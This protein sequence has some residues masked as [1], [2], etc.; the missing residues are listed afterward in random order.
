MKQ[1]FSLPKIVF[2]LAISA[3]AIGF[4]AFSQTEKNNEG[5]FRKERFQKDDTSRHAKRNGADDYRNFDQ[6]DTEMKNL[7]QQM[8]KLDEEM[9]KMQVTLSQQQIELELKQVDAEKISNE[10][11]ESVKNINWEQISKDIEKNA[12]NLDKQKIAEIKNQIEKARMQLDK[13]KMNMH[14]NIPK[15]DIE[16]IRLTTEKSMKNA[17]KSME[18]AKE[19]MKKMRDFTNALQKDGLI[20]KSKKYKVQVKDGELYINDQK[21]PKEVSEKYKKYY[22][23][24][25][26]TIEMNDGDK[27]HI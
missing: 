23:S 20:D 4:T 18:R 9:K 26:F 14:I 22:R 21:Q 11:E 8:K 17:R 6:L 16:K 13:Q 25:N 15:I 27:D 24:D 3:T 2:V 12:A 1:H 10:V 19:E 5:S 7:D